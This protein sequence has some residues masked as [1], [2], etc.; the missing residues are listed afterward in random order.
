MK[1]MVERRQRYW[2][3]GWLWLPPVSVLLFAACTQVRTPEEEPNAVAALAPTPLEV[4]A[5]Q[6]PA[7][8]PAEPLIA[9]TPA[10]PQ[11]DLAP[12]PVAPPVP[13]VEP[14]AESRS[15]TPDVLV[16]ASPQAA[17]EAAA[18]TALC[19]QIGHKLS[20]VSVED[21]DKQG[22]HLGKG[23]SVRGR[24]LLVK[25]VPPA[26]TAPDFRVFL[27][28][29]I[30]GDEYS[31]VSILFKWLDLY[32]AENLE[33]EFLWRVAPL[34]NPDGLL[35]GGKAT[36]QNANGVDLNRNFP[37]RDWNDS[38][39]SYWRK[40]TGSNPRRYPGDGAASE[41]E[42]Q[43]LVQ[44]IAEFQPHV[45]VSVHAPYHLLDFD[46][47]AAAPEKIGELQ[48]RQLGVYPGSLGNYAGINKQIPVVTLELPSAGILP[49]Q[50]QI[51]LMWHDLVAWLDREGR[52]GHLD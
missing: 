33:G 20:S 29:G 31:S 41:P 44:Q 8:A 52:K 22:F 45:I 21:C 38:A 19:E 48:L 50:E 40:S 24:P 28:G 17:A 51:T 47:P 49:S 16:A 26:S 34:V 1:A 35:D 7:A 5:T 43:W 32:S 3:A 14:A 37:S 13:P 2:R 9:V 36:R 11:T 10:E 42:V 46:G 4:A 23:A 6:V 15:A 39:V 12:A 18:V 27:M 30:H 25:D